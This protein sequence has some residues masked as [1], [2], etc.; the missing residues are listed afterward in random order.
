MSLCP[1]P[2]TLATS[3]DSSVASRGG[4]QA[5]APTASGPETRRKSLSDLGITEYV[6][7]KFPRSAQRR[8]LSG[9]V[10]VEFVVNPDGSTGDF[11][12]VNA[13]P[14]RVFDGS[15]ENA[16]SR[17]KF[18]PRDEPVNARIVLSFEAAP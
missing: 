1:E 11:S 7:P 6:A 4:A 5:P 10:E 9:F 2:D 12:V 17:W 3:E 8:N 15:A 13:M 14:K 18:A 16:V